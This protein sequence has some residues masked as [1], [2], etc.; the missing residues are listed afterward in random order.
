MLCLILVKN[1]KVVETIF[2]NSWWCLSNE[3]KNLIKRMV[4]SCE[5]RLG[6]NEV[7]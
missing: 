4:C 7:D 5:C 2:S 6:I 1:C 3:V